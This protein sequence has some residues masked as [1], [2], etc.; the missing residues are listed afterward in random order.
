MLK[1]FPSPKMNITQNVLF[2]HSRNQTHHSF[3]FNLQFLH[4]LKHKVRLSKSCV[5][6]LDL[7]FRLVFIKIYIFAIFV[8]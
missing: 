1:N 6:L 3:S 7:G 4:E 5:G 8:Q 2:F